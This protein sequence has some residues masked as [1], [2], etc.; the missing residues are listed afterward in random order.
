MTKNGMMPGQEP[1][2]DAERAQLYEL[3]SDAAA[4]DPGERGEIAAKHAARLEEL[5]AVIRAECISYGEL[6]ELADLAP[7]IDPSDVELL[8]WA[9]VP[10][11]PDDTMDADTG[12]AFNR[13]IIY[14]R[15]LGRQ[16]GANVAIDYINETIERDRTWRPRPTAAED[17]RRILKGLEDGDPAILDELPFADLSGQWADTLTGPQL[18][19][20]AI[21]AADDGSQPMEAFELAAHN[22]TRDWFSDICDAYENAFSDAVIDAVETRARA[23]VDVCAICGVA[24]KVHVSSTAGH[25]Y[26]VAAVS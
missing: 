19:S 11:F 9:G 2:T 1:Y 12:E 22:W 5:R 13:A 17:A 8:Q 4:G 6:A 26:T 10:E 20:D 14:A 21:G 3:V 24:P 7:Y 23:H 25:V 16:H 15:E 18:V